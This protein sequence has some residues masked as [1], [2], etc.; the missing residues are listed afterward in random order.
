MTTTDSETLLAETRAFN[1]ELERLLATIPPVNTVPPEESRRARREGRGI[2]PAPVYVPE[3]RTVEIDGPGGPLSLRI[4]APEGQATGTFLHL[5]GG[6][7]TLGESDAQD[8]RLQRLAR[9]TGLA[10]VSVD[11]RLAPENPYPAGPDDCEA[12]ALWL[13][14]EEG[15]AAVGAPGPRAVGGDSAGGQL[16]AATLLRLRD[17]HGIIGAFG[18]AVLQYG[19]FDLSMTPSQRLWGERNLVLS[20]PIIA[21]FA[22]QFLPMQDRE[23][24]RDPDISPLFAELSGMPPAIFTIGTQDPLLDDTLFMEARWRQAG[25]PTELRIWPEAPHGFVSLPMS[26]ADVALAAEHDFLRRTLALG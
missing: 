15:Q 26:V 4:I 9:D 22:D 21:W 5:H 10:V 23:Q 6:G 20:G 3:A 18:A 19:A 7:W 12:A 25:H 11:Y 1:A 2:F 17:R 14:G 13:L 16:A 8:L 24:R